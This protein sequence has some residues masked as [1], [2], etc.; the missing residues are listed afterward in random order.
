MFYVVCFDI[1]EDRMRTKV[2]KVLKEYGR[3]VQK[4]VFECPTLS[5]E[6]FLTLQRRISYLIDETTDTV[7]YYYLCRHCVKRVEHAGT[8]AFPKS[9]PFEVC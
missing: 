8:G 1:S 9:K 7:R 4:S 3:R 5:E 6:R 2:G